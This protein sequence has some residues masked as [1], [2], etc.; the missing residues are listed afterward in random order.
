MVIVSSLFVS[1]CFIDAN[2]LRIWIIKLGSFLLPLN[3]SGDKK[4]LS[5]SI[6][7]LSSGIILKV[8]CKSVLFLN[9]II[10]LAENY[11]LNFN[12]LFANVSDPVKQC[13]K[14]LSLLFTNSES[15]FSISVSA[16]LE[17]IIKGTSN[18]IAALI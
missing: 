13:I 7:N 1:I 5:V 15:I 8:F 17:C 3:G 11:E 18:S 14:I 16:F 6:S 12:R 4:G 2:F 10:P 9:V